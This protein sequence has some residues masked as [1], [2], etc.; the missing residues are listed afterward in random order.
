MFLGCH[1]QPDPP[2]TFCPSPWRKAESQPSAVRPEKS[3]PAVPSI[4]PTAL[5]NGAFLNAGQQ[6]GMSEQQEREG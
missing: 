6:G 2:E 1:R 4:Y 3:S 5:P